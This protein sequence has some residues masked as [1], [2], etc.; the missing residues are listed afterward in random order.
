MDVAAEDPIRVDL[1]VEVALH[2][3]CQR[4]GAGE[5]TAGD[6]RVDTRRESR[7]VGRRRSGVDDRARVGGAPRRGARRAATALRSRPRPAW[8]GCRGPSCYAACLP[9]TCSVSVWWSAQY[10]GRRRQP[11][12]RAHRARRRRPARRAHD[13]RAGP[14]PAPDRALVRRPIVG[15]RPRA[16]PTCRR[17]RDLHFAQ[18]P[19][20]NAT[21]PESQP[22]L[23]KPCLN[24]LAASDSRRQRS[25]P[26]SKRIKPR[27][28]RIAAS[29]PCWAR[30]LATGSTMGFY[31]RCTSTSTRT[32]RSNHQ[33]SKP[34]CRAATAKNPISSLSQSNVDRS[35]L[36][37]ALVRTS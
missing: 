33:T 3:L 23:P 15:I 5:L 7:G 35:S 16:E 4:V 34:W 19:F 31:A 18:R 28:A 27:C 32:A 17:L 37:L 21:A 20:P 9:T 26:G 30:P 22:A 8:V 14:R 2:R 13:V 29:T 11:H 1:D 36:S 25:P 24:V 12:D 10:R 6:R